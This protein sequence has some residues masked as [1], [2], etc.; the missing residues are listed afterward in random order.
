MR[1]P[2]LCALLCL[3]LCSAF[4]GCG[5]PLVLRVAC[6]RVDGVCR[7]RG[8]TTAPLVR[9]SGGDEG[10][11]PP[12]QTTGFGKLFGK[13]KREVTIEMKADEETGQKKFDF[14]SGQLIALS[15]LN[16]AL[17]LVIYKI[18]VELK[19]YCAIGVG[20]GSCN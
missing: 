8:A 3:Q 4:Q 11:Q 14:T 13:L 1:L 12:K 7:V 5:T 17:P 18:F 9:M 20:L 16:F 6:S 15:L 10:G 2:F 19:L